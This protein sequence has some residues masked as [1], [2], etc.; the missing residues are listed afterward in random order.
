MSEVLYSSPRTRVLRIGDVVQKQPLGPDAAERLDN[1]RRVLRLLDGLPGVARLADRQLPGVLVTV[2]TPGTVLSALPLPWPVEPLIEL[3][4]N[5]AGILGA[6]HRHGV[7]HRDVSPGNVLVPADGGPPT[8]IDFELSGAPAEDG[9]VLVG[10]LPYL[11]PEQTGRTGRPVD[12]R[13]DLYALGAM[14]YEL[15]TGEPPFGRD[16]E[17]LHLMHDHLAK[18]PGPPAG[19]PEPLARIIGRLLNKEPAERYQS[20]EG[21]AY[22]LAHLPAEL[23]RRDFPMRLVPPD[24]LVGRDGDLAALRQ[25]LA[26]TGTGRALALVTGPPGVGKTAL[27][28]QLRSVAGAAGGRFVAGK[29]DQYRRDLGADAVRQAFCAIGG[30]LLTEPEPETARLRDTLVERLGSNAGLAAAV[31][32]PFATLL[33]VEPEA[34]DDPWHSVNRIRRMGRDLL[35]CVASADRPLVIFI[36]DLQW[37]G[38]TALGFLDDMLGHPGLTGVFVV[39][40]YREADV[41]ETHPLSGVLARL[42]R[43]GGDTAVLRLANLPP[44]DLSTLLAG[45]LRI[46]PHQAAP[47][48]GALAERT[49]GNPFDTIE[50][51]NALRRD[52]TLT[53]DGDGWSWDRGAVHR[54][55][56]HGDVVGLLGERIADLPPAGRELVEAMAVLGG[57]ISLDLLGIAAGHHV[58]TVRTVLLPAVE[59]GLVTVGGEPMPVAAFRHDRVQQA[60]YGRLPGDDR[61]RLA[62]RLARRL[63]AEGSHL[64]AAATQYRAVLGLVTDVAER[65]AAAELLRRAASAARAGSDHL[66]AEVFL[67]AAVTAFEPGDAGYPAARAEWHGTLCALGRFEQADEVFGGLPAEQ[68]R[69][70]APDQIMSLISRA[71]LDEAFD[72][73][74]TVLAGLDVEIPGPDRLGAQVDDGLAVLRSW[75]D[76]EPPEPEPV[77][78]PRAA[79]A[80]RVIDR[81][82]T[83]TLFRGDQLTMAWLVV[84]AFG[85]WARRGPA[86]ELVGVLG[87]LC[88]LT[89]AAGDFRSGYR[90]IQRVVAAGEVNGWEPGLSQARMMYAFAGIC[91]FEP[92]ENSIRTAHDAREGLLRAGDL[93]WAAN[94]YFVTVPQGLD[95]DDLGVLDAEAEAAVAFM[96]RIGYPQGPPY[97][98]ACRWFIRSMRGESPDPARLGDGITTEEMLLAGLA[99][100]AP[101]RAGFE[102]LRALNAA[103]YR[104]DEALA[105]SGATALEVAPDA[106][107]NY[108]EAQ[109]HLLA[110]LGAAVRAR[111]AILDPVRR[112]ALA[113]AARSRDFLAGRAA[114]SPA[115][116]RHLHRF[117]AAVCAWAGGDLPA[118]VRHFDA[119]LSAVS[120]V[121]RPWHAALIAEYAGRCSFE[122][123]LD[124][125]GQRLLA[126][127][128][129]GY[130]EWGADGKAGQLVRE[131]PV[132]AEAVPGRTATVTSA[133]LSADA[134]DLVGVLE[135]ARAFSSE[136]DLGRLRAT[137]ERV[138]AAI[139]GATSVRLLLWDPAAG[140]WTVPGDP[141]VALADAGHL[142]PVPAVRY[143]ERTREPMV[144]DDARTDER[145]ARD[146]YLADA[147]HCSL[148][149]APVLS[150]GVPRAM[151]VLENRLT[152]RSFTRS[153]L[154][155]VM[156]LAG[157]LTVSLDNAQLYASLEDQVTER[158]A[159]L[160]EANRRLEFLAITD[161]LT[162]LPNRRRLDEVLDHEWAR[163]ARSEEPLGL[164]MIDIDSFKLYNDHYGHQGG[165]ACLQLVARTLAGNVRSTDLVA[166]YGGEEFCIVMP[167]TDGPSARNAA[168]RVCRAVSA[169]AEP[170]AAA[171]LGRVT[172]SVGVSSSVAVPGALPERLLKLADDAL[173]EAKQSGRNRV[174]E[175][176]S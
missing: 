10:T 98:L 9:D 26:A 68:A 8:L 55:V 135:A 72:L 30:Q 137:V 62:L 146:P 95:L 152:S 133:T 74:R 15:A 28:N 156:M 48:A 40:A 119:A 59:E 13:A 5:L 155:T 18:V 23:G 110:V 102:I 3:A 126:E 130:R 11:A 47:L 174:A 91:W 16:R 113:D 87:N 97:F 157:Q 112:D 27:I 31:L 101:G 83:V 100:N 139:T 85:M 121:N 172:I 64:L 6:I 80:A 129:R 111:A 86:R 145:V 44:A 46:S 25:L 38:P 19:V 69:Q 151:L 176:P 141:P 140:G 103:V 61:D 63:A 153:R 29:F 45:I 75:L 118:A 143:A 123:G 52:G 165:D 17:P 116:F 34:A 67:A 122:Y 78:D 175:A 84:T 169:L 65:R 35:T 12:H 71:R 171:A 159:E 125:A 24:G 132:L 76:A 105:R 150:Q 56:S 163:A 39:G 164:A 54:F 1:E 66:S 138:L 36:D 20:G 33:G 14:L 161:P 21:L 115:N 120:A 88:S 104:D 127:A 173:Y 107:G 89:A 37:A 168:E 22:D 96:D 50:M 92:L 58:D 160:A 154:N 149:V 128:L 57:E 170:H 134:I 124:H 109:A 90:A 77:T 93:T 53:P 41:T 82:V 131:Y 117:A 158:T 99:G 32:P 43:T 42:D 70:T 2:G 4:R 94:T 79:D 81:M 7:V 167:D 106:Q 162:G 148:L 142:V 147:E 114:D 144:V 51:L 49:G 108:V 60:A 73:G 166:R 136:T